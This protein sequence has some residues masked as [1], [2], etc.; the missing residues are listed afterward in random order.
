MGNSMS[1]I[2][3]E[4][5]HL[6]VFLPSVSDT[7]ALRDNFVILFARVLVRNLPC[8]SAFADCVPSHIDHELSKEM[9][10]KSTTVSH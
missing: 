4:S 6:D 1:L 5:A 2:P 9:S 7:T 3:L 8:L 10:S